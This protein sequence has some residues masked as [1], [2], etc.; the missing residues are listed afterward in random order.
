MQAAGAADASHNGGDAQQPRS[1]HDAEPSLSD[2]SPSDDSSEGE[3]VASLGES[4]SEWDSE[5]GLTEMDDETEVED[6]EE[7]ESEVSAGETPVDEA[8]EE[9]ADAKARLLLRLHELVFPPDDF[10]PEPDLEAAKAA[11]D[12]AKFRQ[13]AAVAAS[14][15]DQP[16]I[17]FVAD[18]IASCEA[19][20]RESKD[21]YLCHMKT[22][23][24]ERAIDQCI[25]AISANRKWAGTVDGAKNL[26]GDDGLRRL[27]RAVF[28]SL[29]LNRRDALSKEL[30]RQYSLLVNGDVQR[31]KT[32]VEL[33]I[34]I[35]VHYINA[36]YA[37]RLVT[38]LVTTMCP[39]AAN[40]HKSARA[41]LQAHLL[42]DEAAEEEER[43][44]LQDRVS[45]LD[46]RV[47]GLTGLRGAALKQAVKV[48]WR[49][50]GFQIDAGRMRPCSLFAPVTIFIQFL[51][52]LV[53]SM[54]N[55]CV[56]D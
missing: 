1:F 10:H 35:L 54:P 47:A 49:I 38:V 46:I 43:S 6:E 5:K 48:Q 32:T 37:D 53:V 20:K 34:A 56:S 50:S 36:T 9:A 16:L 44:E 25:T 12:L 26:L 24:V 55:S 2:Y 15:D 41:A 29:H 40:L 14:V 27:V 23:D 13:L 28:I 42:A 30:A 8:S 4:E 21:T 22:D 33:L 45:A 11:K 19:F 39:W 31:G 17:D 18:K 3:D 52:L 7:E 51:S